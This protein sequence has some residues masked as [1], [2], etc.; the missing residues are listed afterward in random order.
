MFSIGRPSTTKRRLFRGPSVGAHAVSDRRH[1]PRVSRVQ[2]ASTHIINK[3]VKRTEMH[4]RVTRSADPVGAVSA[5][6]PRAG[7]DRTCLFAYSS[8]ALHWSVR[9]LER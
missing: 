6:V 1:L 9:P 3:Y 4:R 8:G 5:A 7:D 2:S